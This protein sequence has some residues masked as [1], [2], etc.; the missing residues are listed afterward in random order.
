MNIEL[1]TGNVVKLKDSEDLYL[2]RI[3]PKEITPMIWKG[4]EPSL[5][6]VS[7]VS[8]NTRSIYNEIEIVYEDYTLGK[9]I[10]K[11]PEGLSEYELKQLWTLLTKLKKER[12]LD[13]INHDPETDFGTF[14]NEDWYDYDDGDNLINS[15]DNLLSIIEDKLN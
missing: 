10:Y 11:R 8:G 6:L 15:C 12:V 14:D 13:Y 1:K 3:K 5:E 7:L 2:V 9:V 4:P